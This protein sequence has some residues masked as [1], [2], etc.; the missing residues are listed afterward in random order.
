MQSDITAA[1]ARSVAYHTVA[2]VLLAPT[3]ELE[4]ALADGTLARDLGAAAAAL[5]IDA[6]PLCEKLRAGRGA[7]R[8]A[9]E[10]EHMR[11]FGPTI[12]Q[13]HPPYS[14][15]YDPNGKFRKE[16][17]L[18]DIAGFYRAWGLL[19]DED[20]GERVDHFGVE[21][22]Y[23]AFLAVKEAYALV[24]GETDGAA[25]VRQASDRFATRYVAG[26]ARELAER[27]ARASERGLL[28]AAAAL[29]VSLLLAQGIPLRG[30]PRIGSLPVLP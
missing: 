29:L 14:T 6:T 25:R 7:T 28:A 8:A 30:R 26:P 18:A 5:A 9:L 13:D 3:D 24:Q 21:A 10:R 20:L 19:L 16:H 23:L 12:G 4:R 27:L 11:L 15:E 17:E 1:R 22:D 2:E